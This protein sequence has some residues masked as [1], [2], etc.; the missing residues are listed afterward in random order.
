MLGSRFAVLMLF[1]RIFKQW[2]LG[3]IGMFESQNY[4]LWFMFDVMQRFFPDFLELH[5]ITN[6]FN[7]CQEPLELDTLPWFIS[8]SHS[9][10]SVTHFVSSSDFV[11]YA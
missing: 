9:A 3:V 5:F 10:L 4:M 8:F 7:Y 6:T 2:V 1:T 11:L